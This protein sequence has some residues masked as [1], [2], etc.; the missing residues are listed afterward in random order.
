M[1]KYSVGLDFGTTSISIAVLNNATKKTIYVDSKTHSGFL[2]SNDPQ[3]KEQNPD[4]LFNLAHKMLDDVLGNFFPIGGIGITGQMHGILYIDKNNRPVSP[5]YTW[6]DCRAASIHEDNKTY[7]EEIS[8]KTGYPAYPGY[9]LVTHYYLSLNHLVP[10]TANK[11][12]TIMD[13][14]SMKLADAPFPVIHPTNAASLGMYDIK[15][16]CF[17]KSVLRKL[18]FDASILPEIVPAAACQGFYHE[19]PV[20]QGVG[21]NQAS[22]LYSLYE[23]PNGCL[24]NIGTGSQVSV[25][26]NDIYSIPDIECRPFFD[27][28]YLLVGSGLCGGKA[29]AILEMF[30]RNYLQYATGKDDNQYDTMNKLA[31]MALDENIDCPVVETT[32]SGTRGDPE[33]K[34][35]VIGLTEDNFTPQAMILGTLKGMTAELHSLYKQFPTNCD[36]I[37]ASGNAVRRNRVLQDIIRSTFGLPYIILNAQEEAASGAALFAANAEKQS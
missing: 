22:V 33:K 27:G 29:Y 24:V 34:G 16:N 15:N 8:E 4:S 1:S 30:F 36:C 14:A 13:Y 20:Y 32:F 18:G 17:D 5:L 19:I 12:C 2:D 28:K 21:D 3:I 11:L 6:Q 35:S 7:I 23:Y 25:I 9:G 37:I 26:S 10:A 31:R